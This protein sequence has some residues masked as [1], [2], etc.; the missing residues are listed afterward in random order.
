MNLHARD[1]VDNPLSPNPSVRSPS[2]K[3]FSTPVIVMS[4]EDIRHLPLTLETLV[5]QPG[6]NPHRV[7][8]SV[9]YL[10]ENPEVKELCDLFEFAAEQIDTAKIGKPCDQFTEAFEFAKHLFPDAAYFVVIEEGVLLG[11]DFL[12]YLGQLLPLL[13]MDSTI[14]TISAWNDNG[15]QGVSGN[16]KR[17]FRVE[18]LTGMGFLVRRGFP[19]ET[20]C[21]RRFLLEGSPSGGDTISPDVSRVMRISDLVYDDGTPFSE[22]IEALLSHERVTDMELGVTIEG[23]EFLERSHYEKVLHGMLSSSETWALI[24]RYLAL[25]SAG[26]WLPHL[27]SLTTP[28]RLIAR[29]Q[30]AEVINS[31][32]KLLEKVHRLEARKRSAR[33]CPASDLGEHIALAEAQCALLEEQLRYARRVLAFSTN[34]RSTPDG[35]SDG[36]FFKSPSDDNDDVFD[37]PRG[38]RTS[39]SEPRLASQK[40]ADKPVKERASRKTTPKVPEAAAPTKQPGHTRRSRSTSAVPNTVHFPDRCR[41]TV[42]DV[43]FILSKSTSA[44]HSLPANLQNLVSLLKKTKPQSSMRKDFTDSV[45]RNFCVVSNGGL[46][47][48]NSEV[49]LRAASQPDAASRDLV[50]LMHQGE[51]LLKQLN[52]AQMP[53]TRHS[54]KCQCRRLIK[55]IQAKMADIGKS[56]VC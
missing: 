47:K 35:L 9:F 51:H 56:E 34:P 6:I 2:S 22:A 23:V 19:A 14:S 16:N 33:N 29:L 4:G 40:E 15:F 36:A 26:S 11:P 38:V 43:P 7:V 48:S 49:D 37:G 3:I 55:R 24:Q 28:K 30:I 31:L 25:C 32:A 10:P 13:D 44:S 45:H 21:E 12:A 8:A 53:G 42:A 50:H 52:Q 20:W 41:L 1:V 17:L 18:S 27:S 54:L 46:P 39:L 5:M